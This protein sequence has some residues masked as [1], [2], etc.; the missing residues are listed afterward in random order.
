[1]D[2][3]VSMPT[4]TRGQSK[5]RHPNHVPKYLGENQPFVCFIMDMMRAY[6]A[7]IIQYNN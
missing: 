1:M 2:Y 3:T 5:T 6:L 7:L 4:A